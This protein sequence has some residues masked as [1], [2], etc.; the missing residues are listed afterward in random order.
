MQLTNKSIAK[1]VEKIEKFFESANVSKK[2]KIKICLMIE[3][4]LLRYQEKFGEDKNFEL[5]TRKWFGTPK[6]LIKIKGT[7]YNPI[8]DNS[9]ENIFSE[10]IIKNLSNYEQAGLIYRYENG[11]N[12]I[13][14]ATNKEIKNLKIPGGSNTI[15]ILLAIF[16]AIFIKEF[17]SPTAQIF[18]TD[19]IVTPILNKLFGVIIAVNIPLIF[20]SIVASICS[21][22]NVS[23]LHDLSLKIFKRFL[24]ILFFVSVTATAIS[25]IFFQVIKFDFGEILQQNHDE[26]QKVFDLILSIIPKNIIEPFISENVLQIVVLALITGVC[27]TIL[28][29]RVQDIKNLILNLQK[30]IIKMVDIVFKI[31]PLIIF[32]CVFKI[33]LLNSIEEILSV[34]KIVATQYSIYIFLSLLMLFKNYFLYKIKILD[35]L[36]TIYPVCVITFTTAS[37]SA[38]MPKNIEICR[39]KLKISKTLCDFYIPLSHPMCPIMKTVAFIVWTFFAAQFSGEQIT[40][41]QLFIIIFFSIQFAIS[42]SNSGGGGMM[43]MMTLLLTQINFSV[44]SI[45]VIMIADIFVAQ[46]SGVV[47]IIVRDCNLIDFSR[48]INWK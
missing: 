38:S 45:G 21:M 25:E 24:S 10:Q 7:P 44:D 48:K 37:G 4:S 35:F 42:S 29:E 14:A 47:E 34:W 39:E 1:T 32:L 30:I 19:K 43:A 40:L 16:L 5:V 22:E 11:C 13:T 15:S 17:F 46:I 26:M 36:K 3:E 9:E 2:D 12:E 31:I 28:G 6:I 33:I 27:I 8:E 23:M 18:I 41:S 20:T